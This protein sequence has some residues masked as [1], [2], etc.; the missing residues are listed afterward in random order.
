MNDIYFE[1]VWAMPNGKT[2]TIKPIKEFVEVEVG[3]GGVIVDPFANTCKYGTITNDLNPEYETDYHMDA[4]QFLKTL[5]SE[6]ADLVLYDPPYSITQAS[7][8]YKQYGKEK[9]ETNVS[10]MKYWA[11]IKN[12]IAR[13]LKINGRVISCGWN[14]NGLGKGRG[15]EM[16]N[17]MIVNH[18]GS[19]NDTLVTL[20]YKV[21]KSHEQL[22]LF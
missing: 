10:N 22:T 6:S 12:E 7:Q 19:K 4:L 8:L 11:E 21:R 16:T 14:T 5:D 9:L 18:G 20:E 15:F 2:F 13:I 3:R 1:K 17:V